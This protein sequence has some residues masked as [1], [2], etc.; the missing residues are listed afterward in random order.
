MTF[1]ETIAKS[2]ELD[3][4][5]KEG[6]KEIMPITDG[7]PLLS[8]SDLVA[9][10]RAAKD[11]FRAGIARQLTAMAQDIRANG[12][13]AVKKIKSERLAVRAELQGLLGN[14]IVG[15]DDTKSDDQGGA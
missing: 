15:M 10:V 12:E 8:I 11:E 14:E 4:F 5:L 9:D 3:K 1:E 2:E 13:V 6:A 7:Q